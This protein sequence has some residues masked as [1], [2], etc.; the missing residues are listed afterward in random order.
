MIVYTVKL[1]ESIKQLL[2]LI[3][4]HRKVI[5]YK[6]N[7]QKATVFLYICNEHW[8]FLKKHLNSIKKHESYIEYNKKRARPVY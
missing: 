8:I 5:G 1:E 6:I 3:F 7:A 4:K 2:E